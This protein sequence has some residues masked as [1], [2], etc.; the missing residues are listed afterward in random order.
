MNQK[1]ESDVFKQPFIQIEMR[2]Y[3]RSVPPE[4]VSTKLDFICDS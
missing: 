4:R 1:Y 3:A 2:S